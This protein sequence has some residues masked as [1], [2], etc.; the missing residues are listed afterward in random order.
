MEGREN[1]AKL[2]AK[3]KRV[4]SAENVGSSWSRHFRFAMRQ[5]LSHS[6]KEEK[7][8]FYGI[9]DAHGKSRGGVGFSFISLPRGQV[10]NAGKEAKQII[11]FLKQALETWCAALVDLSVMSAIRYLKEDPRGPLQHKKRT[12]DLFI[13]GNGEESGKK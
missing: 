13:A 10:L 7:K 1:A 5:H 2:V 6:A 8:T 4:E 9:N 3:I 11:S 12:S